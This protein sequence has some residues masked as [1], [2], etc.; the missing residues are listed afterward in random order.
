METDGLQ[1]FGTRVRE[2]RQKRQWDVRTLARQ[3]GIHFSTISRVEN[4]QAQIK[5]DTAVRICDG[6]GIPFGEL[7]TLFNRPQVSAPPEIQDTPNILDG[8]PAA[9]HDTLGIR[10][11]Q[12]FS[13]LLREDI[14]RS[15]QVINDIQ[16]HLTAHVTV[17]DSQTNANGDPTFIFLDADK[18]P[19][20]PAL[21]DKWHV[22]YPLVYQANHI[23]DTYL[24]GGVITRR[25]VGSYMSKKRQQNGRSLTSLEAD[26]KVSDS[27]VYRLECGL[28][29][30]VK[31]K[32]ALA[33]DEEIAE[34][35]EIIGMYWQA[36]K[37]H[38]KMVTPKV[39]D[40]SSENTKQFL[41][42]EEFEG[43]SRFISLC[44]WLEL[45]QD[46]HTDWGNVL[47]RTFQIQR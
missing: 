24:K 44:R 43:V 5:V 30:Q 14:R 8:S 37:L 21:L 26:T 35:G 18:I 7:M 11:V 45:V 41:S 2:I 28:L 47:R 10:D 42:D 22:P 27:V 33:L 25:D 15:V 1:R 4:A 39:K 40:E 31:L 36:A 32:D 3:T 23:F 29:E 9:Q 34:H 12:I 46:Y 16:S 6:L 38:I 20:L 19:S 13:V 17:A